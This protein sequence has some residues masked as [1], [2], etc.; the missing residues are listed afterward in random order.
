MNSVSSNPLQWVTTTPVWGAYERQLSAQPVLTKGLTS[1]VG[2][3]LG[4]IIAQTLVEQAAIIDVARVVKFS[5]FGFLVHGTTCHFFYNFLDRAVPGTDAKPVATKVAVDQLLWNPVF[6]CMFFGYLTLY[7]GG[8]LS[9]AVMRIQQS[10]STQVT[11]SWGFWGPAH[12]INFR[13]VPTEQRL[14]Y[15]NALQIVYNV[16]LS[17][18]STPPPL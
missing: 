13:F 16:F 15:I 6:G 17:V 14:L 8:S 2:F 11:G 7:D 18:I 4:D 1:L 5:S 3:A 12:V 9:Q 10:L